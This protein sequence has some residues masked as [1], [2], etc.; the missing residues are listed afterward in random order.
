[1]FHCSI[2]FTL[3]HILLLIMCRVPGTGLYTHEFRM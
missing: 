2:D 1:M 3:V